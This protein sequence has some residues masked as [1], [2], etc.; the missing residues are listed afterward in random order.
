MSIPGVIKDKPAREETV[1]RSTLK[2]QRRVVSADAP[3]APKAPAIAIRSPKAKRTRGERRGRI[4][5]RLTDDCMSITIVNSAWFFTIEYEVGDSGRCRVTCVCARCCGC[6]ET[7]RRT[8]VL[9]FESRDSL[10]PRPM[11]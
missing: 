1:I 2:R 7:P 11:I 4:L 10:T 3:E 9:S 5:L 6:P 8:H